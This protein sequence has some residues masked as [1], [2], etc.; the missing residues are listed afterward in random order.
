MKTVVPLRNF[1][2][3]PSGLV[4]NINRN[5]KTLAFETQPQALN[6]S[7]ILTGDDFIDSVQ[8]DATSGARTVTL[9]PPV[10]NRRR[11]VIKT[12][13]SANLVT[14]NVS[15]AGQLING[16]TSVILTYQYEFVT[17]EATGT[18]WLIVDRGTLTPSF[19]SITFPATQVPSAN[20]NTL[21]DYE[22]GTW[23]PNIGGTATYSLQAGYYT[24]IGRTVFIYG[25]IDINVIGTGSSTVLGGLPFTV[26]NSFG[27]FSIGYFAGLV[28]AVTFISGYF[29]AGSGTIQFITT[30]SSVVTCTNAANVFTSGTVLIFG[31]HYIV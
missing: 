8:M 17:V 18:G 30:A 7:K 29:V 23:T 15:T 5:L 6:V 27:H 1:E 25:R 26:N 12:D 20:P 16:G 13:S 19:N 2:E 28:S 14:I 9:P 4:D 21:D 31:G 22:E 24:K 11:R 10:G 3:V